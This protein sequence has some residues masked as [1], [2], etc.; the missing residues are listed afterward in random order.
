MPK[1]SLNY[2]EVLLETVDTNC[3][4]HAFYL[5][6]VAPV[7]LVD[8][9]PWSISVMVCIGIRRLLPDLS[10]LKCK[11]GVTVPPFKLSI[12]KAFD[13]VRHRR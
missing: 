8:P 5:H 9:D 10:I 6:F 12:D 4:I 2:S 1:K 3:R 13:Y 7:S 11:Y